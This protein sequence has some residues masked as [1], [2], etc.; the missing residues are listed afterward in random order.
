MDDNTQEYIILSNFERK[1]DALECSSCL[2]SLNAMSMSIAVDACRLTKLFESLLKEWQE[3]LPLG[4]AHDVQFSVWGSK[5]WELVM[6]VQTIFFRNNIRLNLFEYESPSF[7]SF[8]DCQDTIG[9][10]EDSMLPLQSVREGEPGVILV[11]AL[12]KLSEILLEISEFLNSPTESQ[13][14]DSFEQWRDCY[15]K[16]YHKLCQKRYDKWKIRYTSRTLK[17]N[18]QERIK[19]ETETF[20]KMFQNDDEFEM[21]Y[22][23]E[24][25]DIDIEGVSRFLF[26]NTDRFGVSYKGDTPAFSKELLKLFNF[27]DTWTMMKND[28]Q[29]KKKQAEKAIVPVVD[30]LELKVN[31]IVG[32]IKHLAAEQWD[33]HLPQ[34]WKSIYTKFKSEISKAGPHEKF[35][36][37]SKKTL[38]CIIGHLKSKGIYLEVSNAELTRYLEGVNNGMRKYLNN[39]LIELDKSLKKRIEAFLDQ[40]I[41]RLAA[42]AR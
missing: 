29:P 3:C 1:V 31:G 42:E 17:K 36:E 7:L 26:T 34:L 28:L 9:P 23:S 11:C 30:E 16:H 27:I 32:K 35:R 4:Y 20:R 18:L 24:K 22:D 13:I 6:K 33:Q 25:M 10:I 37:F 5:I 2:L 12:R 41:K 21:V 8:K 40:E 14:S 19:S 38:Y 15:M 39:G